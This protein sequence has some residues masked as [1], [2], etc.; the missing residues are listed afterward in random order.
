MQEKRK[1]YLSTSLS[2][3]GVNEVAARFFD[4]STSKCVEKTKK[5][6]CSI[7]CRLLFT[8]AGRYYLKTVLLRSEDLWVVSKTS[9]SKQHA[10]ALGR[11]YQTR[12][13]RNE[14]PKARIFLK[15]YFFWGGGSH[16]ITLNGKS[17]AATNASFVLPMSLIT[18][19]VTSMRTWYVWFS[20]S[21]LRCDAAK[22]AAWATGT[23]VKRKSVQYM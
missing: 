11:I 9:N 23:N 14:R 5:W 13:G 22:L 12:L 1:A 7:T 15:P 10:L 18:P 17:A 4:S 6:Q 21:R 20:G 3:C 16:M 8:P 19:S 2:L